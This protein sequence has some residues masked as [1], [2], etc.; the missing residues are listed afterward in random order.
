ML[1]RDP[2]ISLT[3]LVYI[4]LIF[5]ESQEYYIFV[6]LLLWFQAAEKA[7]KAALIV[8]TTSIPKPATHDLRQFM[9]PLADDEQ[10]DNLITDLQNCIGNSSKMSKY[11]QCDQYRFTL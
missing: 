6:M 8:T 3:F 4:Y 9:V 2:F 5:S 10:L 7:L 1:C 11:N